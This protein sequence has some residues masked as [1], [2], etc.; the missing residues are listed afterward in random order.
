MQPCGAGCRTGFPRSGLCLIIQ[1]GLGHLA[2]ASSMLAR[3]LWRGSVFG[4]SGD[5]VELFTQELDRPASQLDWID[6]RAELD[7]TNGEAPITA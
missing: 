6:C 3:T 1:R 7:I 4:L 2:G 5:G